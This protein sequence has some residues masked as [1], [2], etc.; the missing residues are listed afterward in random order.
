M[1]QVDHATPLRAAVIQALLASPAVTAIVGTRVFDYVPTKP[2][3]PYIRI[4]QVNYSSYQETCSI[5]IDAKFN[6]SAFLEG[7]NNTPTSDIGNAILAVVGD[8]DLDLG[9][10]LSAETKLDG[11]QVLTDQGDQAVK[12]CIWRIAALTRQD[13]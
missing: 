5:G 4:G 2:V 1:V 6:I 7:I 9:N 8:V 12:H 13:L 10:G 11:A 3:L